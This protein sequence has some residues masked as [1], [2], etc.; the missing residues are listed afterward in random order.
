MIN[1]KV[2]ANSFISQKRRKNMSKKKLLTRQEAADYL[3][4]AET[5]LRKW[6][7]LCPEKLPFRKVRHFVQ[8]LQSD[9]DAYIKSRERGRR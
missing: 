1:D 5:T 9:L 2:S 7:S 4:L 8:Y 6:G 3:G